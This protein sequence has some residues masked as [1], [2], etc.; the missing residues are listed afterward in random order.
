MTREVFEKFYSQLNPEQKKAVDTLEGP[1]M[2]VAGPGTGK[3][4]VLTLRI[5]NIIL[6]GK[7]KPEEIL[8]LTFTENAAF[9]MKRRLFEILGRDAYVVR[10]CTFHSFSNEVIMGNPESFAFVTCAEEILGGARSISEV[11]QAQIIEDILTRGKFDRL[12]IHNPFVNYIAELSRAISNFKR[13]GM[14]PKDYTKIIDTEEE[15]ISLVGDLY[16]EKGAHKGKMKAIYRET[17]EQI[18]KNR[19]ICKVYEKYQESLDSSGLYDYDDMILFVLRALRPCILCGVSDTPHNIHISH[20][21]ERLREQY[22]YILVDEHQDA[23]GAQNEVVELLAGDDPANV[24][25]VGDEKQSIFRFQGASLKNILYFKNK[26]PQCKVISLEKNYRSPQAIIDCAQSVIAN[27]AMRLGNYLANISEILISNSSIASR[28][29]DVLEAE[30]QDGEFCFIASKIKELCASGVPAGEIAVLYRD[31]WEGH[32]IAATLQKAGIPYYIESNRNIFEDKIMQGFIKFLQFSSRNDL[33]PVAFRRQEIDEQIIDLLFAN[34]IGI[35]A[36]D[37]YRLADF[38]ANQ[39]ERKSLVSLINDKDLME[40]SRIGTAQKMYDFGQIISRCVAAAK[41]ENAPRA[42]EAIAKASGFLHYIV[43]LNSQD[44]ILKFNTLFNELKSAAQGKRDYSLR[45]FAEHLGLMQKYRIA[46]SQ[47][48][49][50]VPLN[51]VRLMTAHKS[52][53]LE[54]DYVLITGCVD[55]RWGGRKRPDALKL[56]EIARVSDGNLNNNSEIEDARRLF[57]VAFTRAKRGVF[58]TF[59]LQNFEG[60]DQF[61]SRFIGEIKP[62]LVSYVDASLHVADVISEIIR[63]PARERAGHAADSLHIEDKEYLKALFLKRGFA[64]THLNN[65]LDC[66]WKYFFRNLIRLPEA[67]E[68]YLCYG[69]AAHFALKRFFDKE[70]TGKEY[71][72]EEFR[73]ALERQPLRNYEFEKYC[74]RGE[75]ALAAYFETY[76]LGSLKSGMNTI[77]EFNVGSVVLDGEVRLTGKIDKIELL[78]KEVNVVDYKTGRR[79]TRGELEGATKNSKGNEKRQLVFYK[80]LLDKMPNSSYLMTSGEIDF[81]E[82]EKRTGKFYKE[83]FIISNDDVRALEYKIQDV[84]AEILNLSFWDKRCQDKKCEYC[85]LRGSL[86]S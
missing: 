72:L 62:E 41:R 6:Q 59:A 68:P 67:Q 48:T 50:R 4:Q 17:L 40:Q 15:R 53:G 79:K 30:N 35:P 70:N 14:L 65:Y 31:N 33:S 28:G 61:P 11:E 82:P 58:A 47:K 78:G 74:E 56:L 80:L 29:V 51:A 34:F 13:E 83:K 49:V 21:L 37:I 43:S 12:N 10:I 25:V 84:T 19:E 45:D 69:N 1:L 3:T 2:V 5:A 71:L 27:N 44:A 60:R 9:N 32:E 39:P 20:L 57:Y 73:K 54:F 81:I 23:N 86:V 26:F 52:K 36:I 77:N 18:A 63:A 24:F 55:A 7:A 64:A 46:L 42:F 85:K 38:R 16:H 75:K 66:P 76:N 22:R 8:A